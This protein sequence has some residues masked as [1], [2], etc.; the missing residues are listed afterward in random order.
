MTRGRGD[1]SGDDDSEES[2]ATTLSLPPTVQRAHVHS[3]LQEVKQR[4]AAAR[5][6]ARLEMVFPSSDGEEGLR[7]GVQVGV[8]LCV[9][10]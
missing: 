2:A 7:I 4:S 5:A 8:E 9:Y 3:W 10:R 1:E 6:V